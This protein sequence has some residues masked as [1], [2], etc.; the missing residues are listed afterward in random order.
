MS[1]EKKSGKEVYANIICS[2]FDMPLFMHAQ[3]KCGSA[4]SES[5]RAK[6]RRC[7]EKLWILNK[8]KIAMHGSNL[9]VEI[10]SCFFQHLQSDEHIFLFKHLICFPTANV[11]GKMGKNVPEIIIQQ[12]F[13]AWLPN[14]NAN[15]IKENMFFFCFDWCFWCRC[16]VT[17]VT[18]KR[19][20][21][22]EG[23]ASGGI[24]VFADNFQCYFSCVGPMN[25][26]YLCHISELMRFHAFNWLFY[27]YT[28]ICA[29][30]KV[31]RGRM[32]LIETGILRNLMKWIGKRFHFTVICIH[33]RTFLS[34]KTHEKWMENSS[35]Q[36][37]SNLIKNQQTILSRIWI[38]HFHI[39]ISRCFQ[40]YKRLNSKCLANGVFQNEFW[41]K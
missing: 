9:F 8:S 32:L 13:C 11:A 5:D 35:K 20:C 6:K 23:G 33:F 38:F 3:T 27:G 24:A 28:I 25:R 4:K 15:D 30:L 34:F 1:R 17:S 39:F 26:Y 36:K 7:H 12:H 37:Y 14:S 2:G 19:K 10:S 41:Q 29:D 16:R 18:W 21:V 22:Y 40:N 31:I